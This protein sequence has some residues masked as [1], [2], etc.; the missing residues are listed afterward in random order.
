MGDLQ[1]RRG[2]V[3]GAEE[4]LHSAVTL[5]ETGLQSLR[6]ER[7]GLRWDRESASAYRALV[8]LMLRH[9]DTLGALET[10]EWYRGAA[11]RAGKSKHEPVRHFDTVSNTLPSLTQVTVVSY[12]LLPRGLAIWAY[13]NRGVTAKLVEREPEE[14]ERLARRFRELSA[15]PS[16]DQFVLQ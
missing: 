11:L 13:D 8:E 14:V 16:S 9:Q 12:G 10:W 1:A 7:D 3:D 15:D 5:A 2:D 6:S 4:S